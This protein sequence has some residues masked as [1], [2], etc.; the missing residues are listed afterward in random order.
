VAK[1]LYD[2]PVTEA[3]HNAQHGV[4]L[5]ELL[6]VMAIVGILG[7]IA[8]P[9]YQNHVRQGYRA[10]AR[11]VL[12]ETVQFLE[13]NYTTTNRYDQDSA[14]VAIVI[15]FATSPKPGAGTAKYNITAAYG[16]C[17][18]GQCFTLSATPVAG[19]AMAG[20]E[21]GTLTLT[22]AGVQGA[23]AAIADCWQR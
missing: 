9:S 19:G 16:A 12:L 11:G 6:I 20:D 17:G 5:I 22:H 10:E 8:Y 7:A 18:N 1:M 23:G 2:F 3:R 13:R 14:G 15:P 21:C 4:T